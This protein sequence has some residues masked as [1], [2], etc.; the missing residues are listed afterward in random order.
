LAFSGL[1]AAK[2][3][4]AST[5]VTEGFSAAFEARGASTDTGTRLLLRFRGVP[6][7]T[8]LLVPDAIAGSDAAQP[9]A[10]GDLGGTPSPG[11]YVPG[12]NTL[13]LVRVPGADATGSSGALPS[14]VSLNTTADVVL[15][16]GS[17]S[18]TYEVVDANDTRLESA[19]I[20]VFIGV[21][22]GSGG[23]IAQENLSLAPLS[24]TATA[25]ANAPVPRYADIAPTADCS[26]NADCDQFAPKLNISLTQPLQFTAIVGQGVA[27]APGY[28]AVQ[29]TGHGIMV[30]KASVQYA[31]GSGSG[32]LTIYPQ[33]DFFINNASIRVFLD[34]KQLGP[35]I[36]QANVTIDA[37]SDGIQSIPVTLAVTAPS[38]PTPNPPATQP[39][40]APTPA[41][42]ISRITNAASMLAAP[43]VPGSLAAIVGPNLAGKNVAVTFDGSSTP[44]LSAT[45]TEILVQV[46]VALAGKASTSLAV[47]VDGISSGPQYV[48]LAA[49]W[50]AIFPKG[51]LNSDNGVNSES[52][53][54][55]PGS[56]IQIFATGLPASRP[57]TV[58]VHDRRDLV[59][60][61]AGSSPGSPGVQQVNAIVPTDLPA[62]TTE[63]VVCGADGTGKQFCSPGMPFTIREPRRVVRGIVAAECRAGRTVRHRT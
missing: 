36:Y 23:A 8:R 30:W 57:I 17:G 45:A 55:A 1:I 2:A 53:G 56:E 3:S 61:Y 52:N 58:Q 29:N 25:S 62:M 6:A 50:P 37:G 51:V 39:P 54:A 16:N 5:R 32:W 20:P 7:G 38:N 49:A 14:T 22:S 48:P 13:L 19:Q 34:P 10:A 27:Q 31:N 44:P 43:L 47:T 4:V 35:G 12:S 26:V 59:P 60:V 15:S 11:Q 63:V 18:V 9:T 40:P 42:T 21:P 24:T 41:L 28:I 46:P 33:S